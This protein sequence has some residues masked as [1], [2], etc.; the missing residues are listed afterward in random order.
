MTLTNVIN[1]I[2]SDINKIQY[3]SNN[4][5]NNNNNNNSGYKIGHISS[6]IYQAIKQ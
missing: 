4:N 5:N 2:L 3:P 1:S 6:F